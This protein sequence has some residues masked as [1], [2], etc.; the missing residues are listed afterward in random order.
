MNPE[1]MEC[2]ASCIELLQG[3]LQP[4][5]RIE[6]SDCM[7]LIRALTILLRLHNARLRNPAL[8]CS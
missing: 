5:Q 4:A 8:E 7:D 1:Q 6:V 3:L 2:L